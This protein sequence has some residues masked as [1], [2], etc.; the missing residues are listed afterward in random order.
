MMTWVLIIYWAQAA[1]AVP[2]YESQQSCQ[3]AARMATATTIVAG[4]TNAFCIP[5]PQR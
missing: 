2:G 5:G 4:P 1:V 3:D